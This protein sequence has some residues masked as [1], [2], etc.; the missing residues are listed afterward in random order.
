MGS[1]YGQ[2]MTISEA[3]ENLEEAREAFKEAQ[4]RW[5]LS[6]QPLVASPFLMFA[7]V[8]CGNLDWTDLM[9]VFIVLAIVTTISGIGFTSVAF[10][11]DMQRDKLR[12]A[13]KD[14]RKAEQAFNEAVEREVAR[15]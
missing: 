10:A 12:D 2:R 9:G 4:L 3:Q 5:R 15:D 7:A 6:Y 14:V 8:F 13:R 11:T 1:Y